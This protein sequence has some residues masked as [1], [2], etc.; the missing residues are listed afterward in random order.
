M[1]CVTENIDTHYECYSN[2]DGPCKDYKSEDVPVHA[3]EAY[4]GSRGI[5]PL[6]ISLGA[7]RRR[8]SLMVIQFKRCVSL[9]VDTEWPTT[10]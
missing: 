9:P 4:R 10:A 1:L 2:D 5:A 6:I 7:R 3:V 8:V